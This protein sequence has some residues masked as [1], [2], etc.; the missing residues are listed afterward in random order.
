MHKREYLRRKSASHREVI[1]EEI[2][3]VRFA[4]LWA[5][6]YARNDFRRVRNWLSFSARVWRYGRRMDAPDVIIG[7]SPHLFAALA[8]QRIAVAR[9]RPFVLEVRD[10]WPESLAVR[11]GKQGLGYRALGALADFLYARATRIVVLAEGVRTYL[12]QRGHSQDRLA[13]VP[14]GVDVTA[15]VEGK[16]ADTSVVSFIYAGAHGPANGLDTVL[17]AA[18][19]LRDSADARFV[20]MGDGPAKKALVE[21]AREMKLDNVEFREPVSKTDIPSALA[22]NSA[23]LMVLR[24]LPLFAFGVSPNKLFDYWAARLPVICNVPGEVAGLVEEARGGVV[25]R[26]SSAQ[27]LADAVRALMT[28]SAEDRAALGRQGRSWVERER[29]RPLLADRLDKVLRPFIRA[30]VARPSG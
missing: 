6:P 5:A 7:S 4:W 20:L 3:G 9:R 24:D 26:D 29:G 8:A 16:T 30:S 10:L 11:D 12:A 14:N 18:A 17:D 27:A 22:A 28:M 25:T 21:R 19:L 15:F 1:E 23:G 13:L 2:D